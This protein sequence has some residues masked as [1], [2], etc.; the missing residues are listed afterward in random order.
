MKIQKNK[1]CLP[2]LVRKYE[3][4]AEQQAGKHSFAPLQMNTQ[5][6]I[7]LSAWGRR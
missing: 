2:V 3:A 6:K 1:H 4:M 7:Q 5:L